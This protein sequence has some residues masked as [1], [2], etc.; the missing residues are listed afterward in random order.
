[1]SKKPGGPAGRRVV[2]MLKRPASVSPIKGIKRLI[3]NLTDGR[4]P[5]RVVLAFIA[6]F[7]FA[8]IMPTQ[9]LLRRWRVM[10][11]SEALKHLTSFKKE[12]SNMLNIINRRKAKRGNGS[13]L[14]WIALVT[15]SMALR[16]GT[17]QG[18]VLMSI[19]KTDV[20]EIIPI[21]TTKGDNLCTVRAMD[22]GY[23]CQKDITYECPRLEPG[24][25][26]EDIDCWCDREAIYVHYGLCTKNH[27]ERRGRRS[28]NIPSHGESQLENRGTPWLDTAKTTKYLTKVENWMI[29]NP[30]YAIV[31]VAAAWMLGSNT[32]QKVIFTIM[33]LL[34]APAYS[35]NCLGVT[36]RDFVEGMSGGTWVDIVLEGDGCVTIMAKDKPTLDIRLLKMEAKDLA[37]VRSYCYHATVTSVSSEARCPTM[38]EAHNPKALDSSYLCKST[39]VDRGWGNGCGLF[40]KGSLQTCVK[41]GCTQKAMGMTIQR[42]NLDYELAIYVHGPTSVAAHGNYTTQLGAKHAAKFSITPSSP[43][44]TANLGEYGEATVDCEPRAALDIDNY[45]VM[46]MNNKHWLVNRDWFHDLDLPWTGPATDVWKNRESLVEF[47]E[48]HATRQTVVALAAQEGALHT[49]LAGAIPVTVAG[50]TLTLTSGHL[51]CRMKLDKLKIKGSTYLMCKDKF[52]FAKNPVDTGHGTIV[53]E[54]QYAGSDGPCRIPITMTENLHDLTPIGRL[55]TVNPFVPSSETAQKI[56]IELEPPFGTS[57][58]LV[59][60]GPNQVKYQWH[61]SGSV[62]GSAF[63]TT[64]KGAQRMAVLGETAW[65]FGSVGGVFNSI[66]K[67]IHG[68]FGGAFRTL[69]GGMSWVTQALMGALLLWLGVSSR[70]RTVSITLLA[71]GGILLFLAMNVH[72]D[73]GCAIDITRRELKCGSGI[74]IHNDVETWRDNYKYHPSTPK[75]FA[76]IIH[77]AYKE[78]ICGVRSASRLE[79]EMW[80]HIAPELNA[81]LEDN[82]VDLSVVVE[83]HKGIYKKAPL[84]LENTSDEMHFGW[85][86]WGK[87]FLFKTQMANSTFVVDGPETKECPTERR[88]WNSLEIEDFGVGI[89]STKVFLKVNGDKTEVCDSMV[90]GTAIK[91]NRAVHSDLGYW[92]ESGKNTSW[93]LERAVLGE[94]RSCTWPESHTLWNEGVEDSD[95]IIPPTLGGPRTHHNKREGYKTQLKG[96]WNEEGPIIIE[97]GECPGTKVTQEESCRNRAASARTTTA[98]G[99]VIRDWCCKN[100]TMPPLR[101]TTKNGCWYGMEIRPKHE[102][103]ETLIKSKV[104]AGTGNDI[105]RFQLGLLMAFVFTQEVLRKRW[106]AR[107]ALPTA[108]LLLA[109]FVLGAFTYSDMIRYFVLVGCAFAESNSGGDVIHLALIAVFNIQPAALVSTFFRN[110]WTNRENLLL[111]IAA[112]MAQMA[113]SDV[114]I[115]IMPIMNA[116]ALA[117]MILKAVSIGTVSTIAMPILS[118]LA[119]PME[120]FGLDVLRCLLLIVGV[121]ALIKERKENLAKK[122]GALLISAGLA[123]TGAFSPLVLQGALMLSECATKRGWPASEVLTAIGM[124]IALAGS[125]ARLDSGTMAIPL[126][127]TSILFVSYVLSGKSTDMWIER[128][129]DVTW[130]EEAEITGTSPRLDVELDDNGDFKMINDPG[131]P[132]WMWASRMG[133]MCMA[134]YNPVLIPV[135][136]AGYWMTRKI[137]K[138]GG[139]LWD[140]PA[141]KQMGRSDMKPGVYRVM[142]SGVLGS[143]QSGVGVMYDGV[144]HTMWHVTQGAALR[145]GEGRL[146]PTWGSVR[147]DLITYGGKW[148]LSATWDGTEEV[149]LIAAEP[150][151]P[152]KNFQTRPGVFKTPAG[153]VGAITL[154]FPKG[155]SGSPIVNKAGAVIGLYGNGLVLSSGAYVSAI[156]QGERQEEE[157]PE[158]F[159]PE[160]LRKRQLTILDLHPG[161]GKTRRVIPQIVREAVKQRLRTVILAPTR[162]VAAEIAEALRGLPVRFQTSAVKAEHS[163]TEIVDVMCHATLTQRL[164]T[165]MRVPNYNVFVMDEAHFTDPASIAAR[166]YISTKVESGEAAAIFMTATPPGTIDPFPDS[167]SPIIDQEAEIPDR[168]WNSGFEWITDYTGKTVWFVPSVRSGNEIA[169]CLTK[170]G[171]KVIQLNRK[172]YETEYQKCKGNDWDYVVTTDISEMGANFGAHR[173]IDSRK[174]V[175]PVIINDGEGRVQLNGPLPITASSAAQRRGRVGRDPT[176]SGDEYYYGGPITNDDTGHAHWIEAKMLL[177]NIQLQNGLVAQLY[178]PERDKVFATDGEYRLRGEQKKHFVELMRTGELPVWL[179]YKVAEA[180]INYTDRR[181]CFDGPHNNTILEDNTEVEIWTRQGE[182]KVLRPRWSD[183][184]VYSDNQALR[185]FKEFA[186]GKRSAGSMMDVMARMPDYFW[187]KTM[188]AADNLYV[189]ATTEKGGRAHRAALEELPDTLETVLLIAMMSLASC[190]ML[191]LMMQ[192]KGI[193][194]TGMGTAV[195]TAVT[196]LL[197]MADVPAPKIAGVLLISFLLMIVLIPEPEKQ[198]SQTDNHLA[199]FLICALLLVSAVSANEMG[200]LDTTKRDLG[201][202]FSGPSAVTTSRW[203]PLKLALALKPATAWAGYAGMTMLLTPLFRH[204]ITTQYI[205]FSLT[206]I[207]SQASALF[208]LNSGYPFVGVDLSVV[209]LLVGCYG[210]YNLPTTMATIGL[211]VGHYAFMIPGWQAEAMRAAQRRTAA[212]VMKNAVVDGI[213]ATDIPEMDTAT[214]IV[215][216]K[217]GQVMLLIISALAILLNP[218][219]MTVVEGGVLIT[220][221]LATL[222]EGN[223]NTVWNS[224][225]AVGVCH[226]MRGGWAA[227]PS[228][229]WTIIRNLEAPKVKRGGIAAPTL[230][231]IWKSRLNQLTREQF[232]EYRKDGIIEVDRTAARRARREGN[233][234]GGHPV[235]RGTAKLRWLVERGFV[236]PLG[237]VVDLG[238]GRGGWSYYCATLR[239]VQEVRGYTKGGPGHEEPMLMQSYGWNIVSM[240]SG[241]DVFYRPTEAC[242]TVLCDIGESS[243]SPGVEEARTLRVL[244]MIEP[245]LRT[246][247]QYC[248]K[249]LCPYTPKV[250]ERLEKLQRKYGGG[251]VRVPLSRNSNHEMYW[252]SEASSNL[253]NAVNAT[254]QVLLQ[255]LEKDHRKGPRYEEDV[256]LGSGTRS[257]ARRSPFMDTR[258][259]HHRI[260]RLKSEFSTTWHYDCEH[261]YRTWNYHGSYEVKPTGSASSMVNGVVKL[262]S[263]PWDSIQSVLTMAMTDTTPFGQQRV[264]KEKVDTKAPEPAPGVKVVLDLTT[265]W[266]WAVLCRRKKPRMCTKEEFIAKVNSHAAL[267]AIFEEQNQ[268][269]SAREAVEDPGFWNLVDKERQA[270]LEGRC[271][272]CI[273]NMMGKR[274]KKLGEFGKAKGSRAIWYMWLGARFLEFEALGFLNE[275]HWMS[276]ENSYGGVEG[277]GLQK[278]GYILQEISRKEGGHMFADDTAG[279]DTRVTLTDL[280]NEAKIT[281][282][283][284]PEHRKLA[285]AM[286]ELTYKNKVVKVTRPGKE[287]KTVM[288]IISRNDQRGSGQVVTYALNTY[289]NLAVQLIRCME[290]EGLLEEEETMRISDAKRRAVQAWLDTNGTERLSRMAVSGDDCVVKP[291]DNRFAT[292]LHFLNGMSKVRKDI[293]EWKPST[294]WTNWQ[295]VP[296]CSHHFNELVMRDG[297]KIVVPCRAQ[298]ELIGRARVSP[299]SGWSLRETACLGKAYAQM[300]LLMYFH[301]RD[302]RL[303]A[304]A[305]CSAVPIDWVPTGRTTWSIHGKGEW[306]TTEDMLAV[307]NRVWIFENEHM[308]DKTPVYSWTD[309]PYIGKREDQWCGSLIGHRS[310][311]TWAENI[312]T[313]IMQVRNLIGAERYVDYMPAQT[314]FAHEAELQGGVL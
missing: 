228:I 24:M 292:A 85:K 1:M 155:T 119:P 289:T 15:G 12:I 36:N 95:L 101:F 9:G 138:R 168:A 154:D 226:L 100:C 230:G 250:I 220:A 206:A 5:L 136:V 300:W 16:L 26:P 103:E 89:M 240:K 14:L 293:Q 185:A 203:E 164:M 68:L 295:E 287:G 205:S 241:I 302:L 105:C 60:T 244:E 156:S 32:S 148:K 177:D 40:G 42:E 120:W 224:T 87:S 201:K 43:S 198:R 272:T 235:S 111:V 139:V 8:A 92:I 248:V 234:T 102:S 162:V 151:K 34:I 266:L 210:Q 283:M 290:G 58:I 94:V 269:A 65:D 116:M 176:Q 104:T 142:T 79:H 64:I 121:A 47:E 55:V 153:E 199:V 124:T 281:R 73:T 189:L 106:T 280:E 312:Y 273:Y 238:C 31:A 30:G 122:K 23:M 112:A 18:K 274:E 56:L 84:R 70:E 61:K 197:W 310:R 304:N 313:P 251:L 227:G 39:Y 195:L 263:K 314:R 188:N 237:K 216:K 299:G 291:I 247:N 214:P 41:F 50:T 166:G 109:C 91:G 249:V 123:L 242:D 146:N 78:G 264:F 165:P 236:K 93:R 297:R 253:I 133:L 213:V 173:V 4:G 175:K 140:L 83:E 2:N 222:L 144:F 186:A 282:W 59:G 233:R 192:R 278:L 285:E 72:A 51:K 7:R 125:V 6:F 276:R 150:G 127:T 145:N 97:F 25:D 187:T 53:T 196:I 158:A 257:V 256:D 184:R 132:M 161:A 270:H 11:K 172:S 215:E 178:K 86:N 170:A 131:V 284:E 202:L 183:A 48:A 149:Q 98:S 160:M 62:I 174:C 38:G 117:W 143:Y 298:D 110:R 44:F 54:V 261:P 207:T 159:T 181:W 147:D 309:V 245:W 243:P 45:Y 46:S 57:F 76:K 258:K 81:I 179:S 268:W 49:A 254:S 67:G 180:G 306:M 167:N 113:W 279:W 152:V 108:A 29:R 229:G 63:K 223:A 130:E 134:A 221:A 52:A 135:S 128:C 239:H 163:G 231:E 271:E 35:I 22:V 17:Y 141:P 71:T 208:G 27:R 114:G 182:R 66:G 232:M 171:K 77:K 115:E 191:A 19:N 13:V 129:A 96:P 209:F 21:P 157:A 246:A 194:K 99:K 80:K 219:T 277:K 252:V 90:M 267:G 33:L 311:A 255:R 212:G 211:L 286:I 118:G 88:A 204:L 225:V 288:D 217:M 308:E 10:N 107:L 218:D 296:F 74:F 193:G 200:W 190:G 82:E 28:V 169:M 307:W 3:G 20:A 294:G 75:N 126:A 303:M 305:I 69:F 262:M 265:D 301:R 137:H 259:I 260:E 37:T 275:D